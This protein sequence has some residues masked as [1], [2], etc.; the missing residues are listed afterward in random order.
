V[1]IICGQSITGRWTGDAMMYGEERLPDLA[2]SLTLRADDIRRFAGYGIGE[3]LLRAANIDRVTDDKAWDKYGIRGERMQD[4]AG[5]VYPYNDPITGQRVTARLRR[6][7]PEINEDGGPERKYMAPYGD[8]RRLYYPPDSKAKLENPDTPIIIVESEKAALAL[9]ALF[10]RTNRN[11]LVVATGGCWNFKKHKRVRNEKGVLVDQKAILY[12]LDFF[13]RR[14]VY[15]I[16]DVNISVN[17]SVQAAERLLIAELTKRYCTVQSCR[18]PQVGEASKDWNGPDDY[19][20]VCGDEAMLAVLDSGRIVARSA[21]PTKEPLKDGALALVPVPEGSQCD[22]AHRFTA[23]YQDDLRYTAAWDLWH[24]WCGS[25]WLE[26][27]ILEVFTCIRRLLEE[28]SAAYA[29]RPLQARVICSAP[30]VAAVERLLRYDTR[31][32]AR[33]EQW[34]RDIWLS[35]TPAGTFDLKT[36][37]LREARR[38]DYITK[39]TAVAPGGDCPLWN[40]FLRKVTADNEEL[41]GFLQRLAGYALTGDISEEAFFFIHGP[42]GGGK[43]TFVETL[44]FCLGDYARNASVETFLLSAN[45][46]HPTELAYLCGARLVTATE[47]VNGRRWD[48]AKLKA[49]TGGD[50]ITARFMRQDFF[51]FRPQFKLLICGNHRPGLNNVDEGFRRRFHLIPFTITIPEEERDLKL[52]EKLRETEAGGIL[53]WIVDG[54]LAWQKEGL[55]PPEMVRAA[56]ED[57]FE[58]EDTLSRWFDEC[59]ELDLNTFTPSANLFGSYKAWAEAAGE[60]IGSE[61]RLIGWLTQKRG[62]QK[63]RTNRKRGVYGVQLKGKGKE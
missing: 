15:I 13:K 27:R 23:L 38:E 55:K 57:Y 35:G 5:V 7:H 19:L 32:V 39:S 9:T 44:A 1:E 34:D 49:L 17:K 31:H 37:E 20:A 25:R 26:D 33:V 40:A 29:D 16:P 63:D 60:F 12:D 48:E 11:L 8:P 4:M 62:I 18:L 3:D 58:T 21:K 42:G 30:M 43:T 24:R 28:A 59:C 45:D 6:D 56:T 51:Q 14:L 47:T 50:N 54:C 46:R 10:Q 61:K 41:I 22:F 52:K 36:G 2:P 53:Q